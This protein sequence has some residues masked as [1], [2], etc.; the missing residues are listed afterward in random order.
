VLK[1]TDIRN[2]LT[3]EASTLAA[4]EVNVALDRDTTRKRRDQLQKRLDGLK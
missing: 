2:N 3:T 1:Q 4:L